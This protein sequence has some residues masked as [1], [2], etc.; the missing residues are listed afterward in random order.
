MVLLGLDAARAGAA[1]RVYD[2]RGF[3]HTLRKG[4]AAATHAELFA[5]ILC[6]DRRPL[7]GA[8]AASGT[9]QTSLGSW[10]TTFS[11]C[12][13]SPT[14]VTAIGSLDRCVIDYCRLKT[15]NNVL[16]KWTSECS[17]NSS[18][19]MTTVL[20]S[21][22]VGWFTVRVR[23]IFCKCEVSVQRWKLRSMQERVGLWVEDRWS[24]ELR[25]KWSIEIENEHIFETIYSFEQQKQL[26]YRK[27]QRKKSGWCFCGDDV[28]ILEKF[29]VFFL[30]TY[31]SV[32][33]P[34]GRWRE[35][36]RNVAHLWVRRKCRQNVARRFRSWPGRGR[37]RASMEDEGCCCRC[38][39]L[40][41]FR[42]TDFAALAVTMRGA[43]TFPLYFLK[44]PWLTACNGEAR[45]L[46]GQL[47]FSSLTNSSSKQPLFSLRE[48]LSRRK[49][50]GGGEGAANPK[51][52]F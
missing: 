15:H 34:A 45:N 24:A 12:I 14:I 18:R 52:F 20:V 37:S 47:F 26:H 7:A 27:R 44:Q 40:S 36:E 6:N 39:S 31:W 5:A 13:F 25:Y 35:E 22:S 41:R 32:A 3:N 48:I 33:V 2:P 30:H 4:A 1:L 9:L 46:R 43:T 21:S 29:L 11:D 42:T 17:T 23:E 49:K 16:D 50:K 38:L 51:N 28:S 10:G 8:A 19:P